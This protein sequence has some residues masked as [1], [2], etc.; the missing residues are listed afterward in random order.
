MVTMKT[1]KRGDR[2]GEWYSESAHNNYSESKLN[3]WLKIMLRQENLTMA[4]IRGGNSG[5]V[6]LTYVD[7]FYYDI[8][9]PPETIKSLLPKMPMSF[10]RRLSLDKP[11]NFMQDYRD[12]EDFVLK[13]TR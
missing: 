11:N 1:V 5:T 3:D 9:F 13:T 12:Y 8:M 7:K 2:K 4:T 10:K 6:L